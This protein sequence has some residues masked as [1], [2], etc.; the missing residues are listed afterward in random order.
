MAEDKSE[1]LQ[2]ALTLTFDE[3]QEKGSIDVVKN[4]KAIISSIQ[5]LLRIE[6]G[7]R[8]PDEVYAD[9][10]ERAKADILLRIWGEFPDKRKRVG[11]NLLYDQKSGDL[12]DVLLEGANIL[13]NSDEV[14]LERTAVLG[15]NAFVHS[16]DAK[17]DGA[18]IFGDNAFGGSQVE[19]IDNRGRSLDAEGN[20][21]LNSVIFGRAA[22]INARGGIIKDSIVGGVDVLKYAWG[23]LVLKNTDVVTPEGVKHYDRH[24]F[25]RPRIS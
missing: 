4:R 19:I 3:A 9:L 23:G 11:N 2:G 10:V 13:C 16:H 18:F 1:G 21:V 25:D 8:N 5:N 22:F 24:I 17:L 7:I 6:R 15:P 14:A 12:E 20:K